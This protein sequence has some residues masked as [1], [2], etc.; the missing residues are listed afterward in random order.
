MRK[1]YSLAYNLAIFILAQI[2]WLALL[3]LW[4]YW[5]VSN[6]LIF[7]K[8]GE[9][10]SPQIVIDTP[11]VFP[12]VGGIVLLVGLSFSMVLIFRHLNVQ[13]RLTRLYDNFIANITHELKSPLSSLQLY[14]ETL[15]S[16]NVPPEKQKEFLEQMIKD[17]TRLQKLISTI[18]EISALESRKNK[19]QFEVYDCC[20][21]IS[22]LL[23]ESVEQFRLKTDAI[24][25]NCENEANISIDV[26]AFKM[27]IDNLIDNSIKYSTGDLKISVSVKTFLNKVEI[28]FTDNG[29]GIIP[30]EQKNIFQKFYRIYD[31]DIPNVKG[32]GLGLYWVKEIIRN[33]KG[34]ISVK[35]EGKG[36]G[37][38]F[39][40]ELPT[41]KKTKNK[42]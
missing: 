17:T 5:Y 11:N 36:K 1:R 29:I 2:V 31:S 34:K 25:F 21:I 30:K 13:I 7:E 24:D 19:A 37:T 28:Q 9:K 38:T 27:V 23:N 40:I 35:S 41:A 3:G 10:V 33:H 14:L 8:V 15:N 18:L 12:F 42:K 6:Y 16:R 32:T 22:L 4:I 20:E 26:N 39:I